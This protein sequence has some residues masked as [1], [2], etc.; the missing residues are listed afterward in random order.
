MGISADGD[1]VTSRPEDFT[2]AGRL[3]FRNEGMRRVG[4]LGRTRLHTSQATAPAS[5][6]RRTKPRTPMRWPNDFGRRRRFGGRRLRGRRLHRF[7]AGVW[8]V[9]GAGVD[10]TGAGPQFRGGRRRARGGSGPVGRAGRAASSTAGAAVVC[11]CCCGG[12]AGSS[13]SAGSAPGRSPGRT[14]AGR[15]SPRRSWD[16]APPAS[17]ASTVPP[18]RPGRPE[19]P[20]P[21]P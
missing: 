13:S 11:C 2:P 19:R 5:S 8:T 20:G 21:A 10:R 6:A 7:G 16:N 1:D 3:V 17:S 9:G 4:Y 18:R 12:C 14:A 15:R